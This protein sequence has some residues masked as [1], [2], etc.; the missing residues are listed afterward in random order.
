MV[1]YHT[2]KPPLHSFTNSRRKKSP[3]SSALHK[4]LIL[5]KGD[6][7]KTNFLFYQ[8][9]FSLSLLLSVIF[10]IFLASLSLSPLRLIKQIAPLCFLTCPSVLSWNPTT[11]PTLLPLGLLLYPKT[12]NLPSSPSPVVFLL[13]PETHKPVRILTKYVYPNN[14]QSLKHFLTQMFYRKQEASALHCFC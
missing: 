11:P 3:F 5:T 10:F 9:R 14:E 4:P 7:S 2:H 8:V 6:S 12:H 1:W 13:G